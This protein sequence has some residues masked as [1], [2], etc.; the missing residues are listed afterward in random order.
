MIRQKG[1]QV[2]GLFHGKAEIGHVCPSVMRFGF[3]QEF[4]QA[5]V[6]ELGLNLIEGDFGRIGIGSVRELMAG[7][8]LQ[9]GGDGGIDKW[10]LLAWLGLA[11]GAR[12]ASNRLRTWGERLS[13]RDPVGGDRSVRELGGPLRIA[14]ISG[15]SAER[16]I[17]NFLWV[18][19]LLSLNLCL[20]NLLPI[21]MLDGGH[22]LFYGI[23]VVRGRPLSAKAQEIGFRI[24]LALVLTLMFLV[25]WN[26]LVH[27]NLFG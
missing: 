16:G 14:E 5:V 26:D 7:G 3:L 18:M 2:G 15:E 19:A 24:G 23:E 27:F 20:I 1:S 17:G 21:P 8:A 4:Q 11:S 22:L 9:G 12:V 10:R 13:R 25:L 6:E